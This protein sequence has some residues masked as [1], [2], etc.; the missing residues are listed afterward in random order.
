M[1][2][3]VVPDEKRILVT[4]YASDTSGGYRLRPMEGSAAWNCDHV[5][6]PERSSAYHPTTN[7]SGQTN[8]TNT[9]PGTVDGRLSTA[10]DQLHSHT[11]TP[12]Y[13]WAGRTMLPN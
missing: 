9:G 10:E 6:S 4:E 12:L 13:S 8:N 1:V 11:W 5:M 2:L 7:Q 3:T